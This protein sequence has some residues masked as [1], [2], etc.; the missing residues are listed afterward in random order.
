TRRQDPRRWRLP[1]H[2]PD[3]DRPVPLFATRRDRGAVRTVTPP[4][5]IPPALAPHLF[6]DRARYPRLARLHRHHPRLR[7]AAGDLQHQLGAGRFLELIA[8]ADRNHE[9]A[10]TA[11]HAVL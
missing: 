11:Y 5:L 10:G 3:A 4:R 8:L 9:G 2:A 6:A 1:A 7:L